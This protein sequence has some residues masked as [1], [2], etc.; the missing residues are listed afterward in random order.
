MLIGQNEE[1]LLPHQNTCFRAYYY[2][3]ITA[4]NLS[5]IDIRKIKLLLS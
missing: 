5:E 3:Y 4:V 2:E 1:I